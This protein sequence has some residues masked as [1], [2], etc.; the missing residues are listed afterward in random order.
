[1]LK[2]HNWLPNLLELTDW[3]EI[4]TEV[5]V[6]QDKFFGLS[7]FEIFSKYFRKFEIEIS[8]IDNFG[9]AYLFAP[10]KLQVQT[11]AAVF[12]DPSALLP[13]RYL[14]WHFTFWRTVGHFR[15]PYFFR[16]ILLRYK[17]EEYTTTMGQCCKKLAKFKKN[18][19]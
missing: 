10:L 4:F 1:M 15:K 17:K 19:K 5:T 12:Y 7:N 13:C 18:V 9:R 14:R 11:H 3:S 2:I 8:K 6:H 16:W